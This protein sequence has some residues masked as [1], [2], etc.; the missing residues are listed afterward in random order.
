MAIVARF[1]TQ[2]GDFLGWGKYLSCVVGCLFDIAHAGTGP[3]SAKRK[4]RLQ[5]PARSFVIKFR[6]REDAGDVGFDPLGRRI[7]QTD[8]EIDEAAQVGVGVTAV[9]VD[10]LDSVPK[11]DSVDAQHDHH[12]GHIEEMTRCVEQFHRVG[13]Q[14]SVEF[15]NENDQRPISAIDQLGEKLA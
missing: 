14:T 9:S 2:P 8:G 15:I 5:F 1:Q 6:G 10:L 3:S 7:A 4:G 12:S 11:F 13:R